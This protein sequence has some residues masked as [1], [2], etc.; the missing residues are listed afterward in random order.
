MEITLG[1]GGDQSTYPFP[2]KNSKNQSERHPR[3]RGHGTN[4][5]QDQTCMICA[6]LEASFFNLWFLVLVFGL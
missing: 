6:R 1:E 4:L 5:N 3:W 2:K